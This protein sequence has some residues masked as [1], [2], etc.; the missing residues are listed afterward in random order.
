MFGIIGKLENAPRLAPEVREQTLEPK[1]FK[2]L[3]VE[4][5]MAMIVSKKNVIHKNAPVGARGSHLFGC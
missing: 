4:H 1:R 3:M 5:V 2:K